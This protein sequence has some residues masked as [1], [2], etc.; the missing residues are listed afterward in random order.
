MMRKRSL[1][2]LPRRRSEFTPLILQ[3]LA[4]TAFLAAEPLLSPALIQLQ[5]S[6]YNTTTRRRR[7]RRI[8]VHVHILVKTELPFAEAA[9]SEEAKPWWRSHRRECEWLQQRLDDDIV[10]WS[11]RTVYE[12]TKAFVFGA[13]ELCDGG[14]TLWS[15]T[16]F[17]L[18][19]VEDALGSWEHG[20]RRKQGESRGG[21]G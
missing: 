3:D 13:V 10:G 8:P 7:R 14:C 5:P 1:R 9:S 16:T 11:S 12:D 19:Q 20:G 2:P 15:L 21:N 4:L 6:I 18:P 17:F